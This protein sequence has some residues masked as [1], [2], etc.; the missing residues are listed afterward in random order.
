M[1]SVITLWL[2]IVLS[3]VGV[4]ILS[5]LVWNVMP[6]HRSDFAAVPREEDARSAL[7]GLSAGQYNVPHV[8]ERSDLAKA[9][10]QEKFNEG[11]VAFLIVLPN[12]VPNLAKSLACWFVFSLVV[13]VVAAYLAAWSLS[14]GADFLDVLCMTGTVAWLAY[15][16]AY[17]QEGVWFGR[18]WS[19]VFKM[20]FDGLLYALLTGAVFG[21]LW[22]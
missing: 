12:G 20:I 5:F 17:V 22:P 6:W 10:Y 8:P 2:P 18:P 9:E 4:F 13:S 7:K 16:W 14:A 11:P 19:F 15:A 21:W 1:V 3:A